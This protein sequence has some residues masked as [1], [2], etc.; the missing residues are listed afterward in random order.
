MQEKKLPILILKLLE[1]NVLNTKRIKGVLIKAQ[2]F[3]S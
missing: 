2:P 1:I 3:K